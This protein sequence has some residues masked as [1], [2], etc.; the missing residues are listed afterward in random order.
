MSPGQIVEFIEDER[1]ITAV[2]VEE[3]KGKIKVLTSL[4]REIYLASTRV[5]HTSKKL[6]SLSQSNEAL[7][8]ELQK[9]SELR[10]DLAQQINIPEL[11]EI[12][13]EED[14]K[15]DSEEIAELVFTLKPTDDHV[16]AIIR[17]ILAD[18][19]YFRFRLDGFRPNPPD[20][21]EQI[22]IQREREKYKRELIEE[23][24]QWL[25]AVWDGLP[26]ALP[27]RHKEII[28]V[29]RDYALY[30]KDSQHAKNAEAILRHADVTHPQA[31]FDLLVRLRIW[32]PYE[33]L[34]VQRLGIR[35]DFSL[36]VLDSARV[37]QNENRFSLHVSPVK[38]D[39]RYLDTFTI[40][41]PETTDIDDALSVES[42]ERGYLIGIHITDVSFIIAPGSVL[43]EEASLRGTSIYLPDER[44]PMFPKVISEGI[45]SLKEGEMRPCVS[46]FLETN[47]EGAILSQRF[48]LS[49]LK[50][51]KRF[52]YE[53][54]DS[55]IS[56]T[57]YPMVILFDIARTW[58]QERL[59]QGAMILPL[60]EVVIR[61][62]GS[63]QI[64][65]ERRNR[66]S[67][68]QILVSE[69]MIQANRLTAEFLNKNS[70]PCIYRCQPEPRQRII[71]EI[72]TDLFL[73]YRQRR[74][75]SRTELQVQPSLHTSL[76]LQYYTTVTSPV[77]RYP[78]LVI[79]RQLVAS[80]NDSP[81]A[82]TQQEL[83]K[84]IIQETELLRQANYLENRRQRYWLLRYLE[85]KR[86]EKTLAIIV[87]RFGNRT[88][89]LLPEYMIDTTVPSKF[90]R[91]AIEGDELK[92]QILG[93]RPM[94]DEL[95]VEL[96]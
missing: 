82:Y 2:C 24:G 83:E 41:S 71:K 85:D 21:V 64:A 77:R 60:P 39:L 91:G 72:T 65:L 94:D 48:T 56:H 43:D 40:D 73:N 55:A 15:Y 46:L 38:E 84:L 59:Q 93:T 29:L 95:R 20:T 34:L 75:L 79:Q 17:A 76:G 25:K 4:D 44:I 52:T 69:M 67:P 63:G 31:A 32:S 35:R 8:R 23:G 42:T 22:R 51:R 96:C 10:N 89:L 12:L 47:H 19:L 27:V 74:F 57:V 14:R 16:S 11:W 80:L 61:V 70:I 54:V 1:I 58:R 5:I 37:I 68:S 9:V 88:Q 62:N 36:Q 30:G 26:G 28:E 86:G 45:C 33:N 92:V 6:I 78:D 7:L 66:E 49:W 90:M 3:R 81:P 87:N 13:S 18:R 50:V 53:N